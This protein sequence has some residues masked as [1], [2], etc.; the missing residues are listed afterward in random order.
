MQLPPGLD[1]ARLRAAFLDLDGTVLYEARPLLSAAPAIARLQESGVQCIIATGRMLT[2]ALKV[3]DELGISSPVV[4]YQGAM[5]GSAEG[6]ILQH[7]P[8]D[9]PTARELLIEIEAAGYDPVAF[10][11]EHVYVAR[12]SET[13]HTYS[14]NAGVGYRVVG[15][16]ANWLPAPVTKLVTWGEPNEMSALRDALLPRYGD[17]AFI[18]KSLPYYLEMAAPGIS[19]AT[20]AE[21][22]CELLG[23]TSD[24]CIAF[25]DGENDIEMLD[26]AG[27][28]VAVGEGFEP[29][30]LHANWVCP[31]LREDGVPRVLDAIASARL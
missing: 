24:E 26:W 21:Y 25:G 7:D 28:G 8:L 10:I 1:P 4:C 5:V 20:G 2:S 27:F 3:A 31:P 22:V 16:L 18:A 19:K 9:I 23:I 6:E 17:R 11:D 29:L 15:D 30:A 12:E 13:A 14:K